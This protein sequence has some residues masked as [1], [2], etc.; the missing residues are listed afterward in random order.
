MKLLKPSALI[1]SRIWIFL[2]YHMGSLLQQTAWL[3]SFCI[4]SRVTVFSHVIA[5][6]ELLNHRRGNMNASM[7][8][9]TGIKSPETAPKRLKSFQ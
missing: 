7:F 9:R 2:P 4:Y 8:R 1:L 3:Y 5:H 6:L